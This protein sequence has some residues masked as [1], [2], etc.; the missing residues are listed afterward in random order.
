MAD[1]E[2]SPLKNDQL[3]MRIVG[4]CHRCVHRDS[5]LKCKAF[6]DGIP[7]DILAGRFVHT[8]RWPDQDNDIVFEANDVPLK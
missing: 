1:N 7:S 6:P 8:R 5:V 4:I 2:D 3:Q